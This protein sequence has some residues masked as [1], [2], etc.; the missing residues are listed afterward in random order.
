MW[1]LELQVYLMGICL[2]VLLLPSVPGIL[3]GSVSSGEG[4]EEMSK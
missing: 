3:L 2:S 4:G 1:G